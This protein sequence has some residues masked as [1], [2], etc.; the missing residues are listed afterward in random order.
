MIRVTAEAFFR[1]S[2][3]YISD[4]FPHFLAQQVG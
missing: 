2:Q 1:A 3:L 4:A